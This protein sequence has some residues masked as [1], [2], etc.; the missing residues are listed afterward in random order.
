MIPSWW[1]APLLHGKPQA[2]TQVLWFKGQGMVMRCLPTGGGETEEAGPVQGGWRVGQWTRLAFR[3][4]PLLG[5]GH[6]P[7]AKE[8]SWFDCWAAHT[9]QEP[10]AQPYPSREN[11]AQRS[12]SSLLQSIPLMVPGKAG[13]REARP[14]QVS[15]PLDH[16]GDVQTQQSSSPL[17]EGYKA[18]GKLNIGYALC[19]R[20]MMNILPNTMPYGRWQPKAATGATRG[21]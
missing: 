2:T 15:P 8:H 19:M 12:G 9:H 7:R 5:W 16:R 11:M 14:C 3:P 4:H 20:S 21:L 17:V 13:K 1:A 18:I 6:S 10:P